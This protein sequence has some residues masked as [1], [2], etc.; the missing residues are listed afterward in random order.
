MSGPVL[1]L[2]A[3]GFIGGHIVR[4]AIEQGWEVRGLRRRP[5]A[6]GHVQGV[7]VRWYDGN[8]DEPESLRAALDGVQVLFHAAAYYPQDSRPVAAHLAYSVQQIRGVLDAAAAAGV[9]RIVYTSSLSTI[10]RPPKGSGRLADER[11]AYVPG[12][13]SASAYYECKYAMESEVL[14]ASATGR[15]IVVT[16]PTLVLGPGDLHLAVGRVI[17]PLLRG[18]GLAWLPGDVNVIDVRD[19]A[20][21]HLAAARLGERGERFILGGHNLSVHALQDLIAD[22]AGVRRPR[23]GISEGVM[24]RLARLLAHLPGLRVYSGHLHAL[25]HWQ[26]FNTRKAHDQLG[27]IARPLQVTIAEM[28]EWYRSSGH[29]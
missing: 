25:S 16:N 8:L 15:E 3:T 29:L 14:R 28:I 1:V 13:L 5:G 6:Q 2:G 11:D 23:W 12:S 22:G 18:W 26:G 24:D 20:D 17:I 7:P 4:A 9:E 21:A 27:L 10:G 19:C